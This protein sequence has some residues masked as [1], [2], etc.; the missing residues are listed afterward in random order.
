[1]KKK[2][3]SAYNEYLNQIQSKMGKEETVTSQLTQMGKGLFGKKY[4]GTFASDQIPHMEDGQYAITNLDTSEQSGTHWISLVKD[5]PSIIV[6]DSFGRRT[7][8]IIPELIGSGN[9]ITIA[10]ENDKEQT[11]L[12]SDCGQRCLAALCVHDNFGKEGLMYI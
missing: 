3:E 12:E 11:D 9:G 7:S 5:G 10:T 4:I 1:M 6:Y 8:K 2:A